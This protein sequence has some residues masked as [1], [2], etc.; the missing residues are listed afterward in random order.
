MMTILKR[1][2]AVAALAALPLAPLAVQAQTQPEQ[3]TGAQTQPQTEN[4]TQYGVQREMLP[5]GQQGDT[6]AGQQSEG[7]KAGAQ[8]DQAASKPAEDAQQSPQQSDTAKQDQATGQ[9][10]AGAQQGQAAGQSGTGAE[11]VQQQAEGEAGPDAIVA[12]V[13][14][15]DIMR[16]DVLGV[17][18]ALPPELQ[19]QPAE[20][21]IP[22]ALDQL[23]LREL[24]LQKAQAAGLEDDPDVDALLADVADAPEEA[25]ENAMVQVWLDRELEGAV[26]DQKVEETYG[27]IE[28][29]LGNQAPPLEQIR[30]QI[31]QELR[32]MAFLELSEDLHTNADVTLFGPDGE[33]ITEGGSTTQ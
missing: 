33:P 12:R 5:E 26:T 15:A 32:R 9:P 21:L 3:Q 17:I 27:T 10:T 2:T 13:G 4:A 30:P 22:M 7:Q 25:R 1:T 31:E 11:Q 14:D 19:Q 29:Q 18:G 16:S 6:R 24:I 8:Q 23:V 28:S 20:M